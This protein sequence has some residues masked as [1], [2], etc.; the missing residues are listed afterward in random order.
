MVRDLEYIH[1]PSGENPPSFIYFHKFGLL[2][3]HTS[4]LS[5]LYNYFVSWQFDYICAIY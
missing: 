3:T 4:P 2:S 5:Y 1:I